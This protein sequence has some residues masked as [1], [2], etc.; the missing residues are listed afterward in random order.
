MKLRLERLRAPQEVAT[1]PPKESLVAV[2][3][4]ARR[5]R[6]IDMELRMR[7]YRLACFA[8]LAIGL[9]AISSDIGWWWIA[10]LAV[11]LAGF[12][13]ADRFMRTSTHP[14]VWVATAWG[15]LPL[16]IADAVVVTGGA[17]SPALMWFALPA[18]TVGARFEPRGMVV[19]AAYILVLL[20]AATY[21]L[22]AGTAAANY[23]DV[24]AAV[25][26]V[27]CAVILSGALVESDR[28]HRRRSTVD[29]LTGLCNRS[30]LEQRLAELDGQ[31][32][33]SEDGLSHALLLC[34]LDHFKRVN[35][36][37]GHAAGDAVL[38]DVAYTMRATLRAG[39]SIYRV[40]GEEIL[41]V[42][43]GAGEAEAM[44]IAERLREAVRERRPVG[45]PVTVSIGV[46]VSGAGLVDA[47]E[48]VG[49]ADAALYAAK[50]GGRDRVVLRGRERVP[51]LSG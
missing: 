30:A 48:L 49:Q 6:L 8:I 1:A 37:L 18:V 11:G 43:P 39:D 22:D 36:Q 16:L 14:A 47:D 38:Q 24:L 33:S 9:A 51:A 41:V 2:R 21:G 20:L 50:S 26:L 28:A 4:S 7:R 45:V 40:G 3:D 12:S 44:E 19:G 10:P 31:P 29:P 42:L 46:A 32:S 15:I 5:E 17:E 34:D 27:V 25:A 13:V 35:D 23:Q